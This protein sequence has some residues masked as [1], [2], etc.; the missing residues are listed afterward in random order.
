MD[1]YYM[2]CAYMDTD[3]G[4]HIHIHP[5][6]CIRTLLHPHMDTHYMYCAH[7]NRH[8]HT[9]THIQ[10]HTCTLYACV[11]AHLYAH[12]YTHMHAHALHARVHTQ[13]HTEPSHQHCTFQ[14]ELRLLERRGRSCPAGA[15]RRH[16]ITRT[17]KTA[18]WG[19]RL[20]AQGAQEI[21]PVQRP[22]NNQS[23]KARASGP[24]PRDTR[25]RLGPHGPAGS[26][27]CWAWAMLAR[28]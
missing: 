18:W 10:P 24:T 28:W 2:H 26:C 27:S 11:P 3:M 17:C 7:M 14:R 5:C 23:K 6:T 12:A 19:L 20:W 4:T 21:E 8:V 9:C 1:T 13:T 16:V 22:E 15:G 25:A